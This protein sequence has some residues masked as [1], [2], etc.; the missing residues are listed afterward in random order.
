MRFEQMELLELTDNCDNV[1]CG[2]VMI[3]VKFLHELIDDIVYCGLP[4]TALPDQAGGVVELMNDTSLAIEYHC[5][6]LDHTDTDI[7][8]LF[9]MITAFWHLW[10]VAPDEDV[11]LGPS[12]NDVA[13]YSPFRARSIKKFPYRD[14]RA[15]IWG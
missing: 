11:S 7:R 3:D 4:I 8:P 5:F 9:R 15:D 13:L 12:G 1:L 14:S 6:T 10:Q 2:C